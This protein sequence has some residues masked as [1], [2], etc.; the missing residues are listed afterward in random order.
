MACGRGKLSRYV[1]VAWI[2]DPWK[3]A[4]KCARKKGMERVHERVIHVRGTGK[5][6]TGRTRGRENGQSVK[7]GCV[8]W[9]IEGL[10]GSPLINR[11]RDEVFRKNDLKGFN[12]RK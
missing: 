2:S 11:T 9:A 6:R 5:L 1:E 12:M 7:K 3:G 8:E 10:S 4:W